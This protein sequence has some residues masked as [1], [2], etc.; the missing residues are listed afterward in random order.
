[1]KRI[2][3]TFL[4]IISTFLSL[5]PYKQ[6]EGNIINITNNTFTI[7]TNKGTIYTFNKP[8]NF[9]NTI[10]DNIKIKYENKISDFI[11]IQN[12]TIKKIENIPNIKYNQSNLFKNYYIKATEKVKNMTTEEK[13]GQLLLVRVPEKEKIETIKK[14]NIGGYILFGRDVANKTKEELIKEIQDYQQNSKIGLLIAIDEEGGKVTR[15]SQNKK[16]ISSP[17]LSSQELYK[18][19]GFDEIKKDTIEKNKILYELG[20]NLNLAPVADVTTNEKAYM[21]KR[22]FG[23]NATLTS[24]YIKTVIENT[25]YKVSYTLKHFPGYGN[26]VDT[27]KGIAIDERTYENFINN[28]FKPFIEGLKNNVQAIL[29]SHNYMTCVDEKNP[30]SLSPNVHNILKN[31]LNYE[32]ITITDDISMNGLNNIENKYTKA[33]LS[34]NNILIVTDYEKAYTEILNSLENKQISEELINYLV[35]QNI[36]WKYYKQIIKD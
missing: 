25:D 12:I 24:E 11:N 6:I 27:H 26:N 28:D 18:I 4:M 36:A 20:I 3:L 10:N 2:L 33:L 8:N 1:M 19:N 14:Y 22:S 7:L 29:F 21:Y 35:T 34:G 30:S 15:L 23:Q 16:I 32:N 9:N 5:K 13:I 17:F 31:E